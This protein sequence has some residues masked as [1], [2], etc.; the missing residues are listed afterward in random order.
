VDVAAA[1]R[2]GISFVTA[3]AT[4]GATYTDP[5][6]ARTAGNARGVAP[7]FGAY[8]VLHPNS[9]SAIGSQVDHFLSVLDGQSPWWRKG[10]FIVQL[11]CER[12]SASDFPQRADIAA[13]CDQFAAR[14]GNTWY[15]IVYASHGQYGGSLSGL[16]RPLWNANYGSD[17][18]MHYREAYPGDSAAGWAAYSDQTPVLLQYGSN[19]TIGGQSGCDANAFRG[20]LDSLTRL[21]WSGSGANGEDMPSSI[22][23]SVPPGFS[24]TVNANGGL[25]ELSG[26]DANRLVLAIPAASAAGLPWGGEYVSVTSDVLGRTQVRLRVAIYNG[27]GWS[28]D[29]NVT[30]PSGGRHNL[31]LPAPGGPS[32][33]TLSISR[34]RQSDSD[35]SAAQPVS[36]LVELGVR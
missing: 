13:W 14:T 25:T 11:D 6:Y 29:E 24:Y 20:S 16:N 21:V 32:A 31:T 35:D 28:I 2:D 26:T 15:P 1:V 8:H 5:E 22:V 27:T 19:L 33:Y 3:K 36:V 17:P 10:P 30:V 12:W 9:S 7:L 23:A 4:E 34:V 18:S